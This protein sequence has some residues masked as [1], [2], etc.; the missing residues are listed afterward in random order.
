MQPAEQ[1]LPPATEPTE[2][3][4][5]PTDAPSDGLSKSALKKLQKRQAKASMKA[6]KKAAAAAEVADKAVPSAP[7]DAELVRALESQ[8]RPG[9]TPWTELPHAELRRELQA[10]G[11]AVSMKR[12]KELMPE[13]PLAAAEAP[14]GG[15]PASG[16]SHVSFPLCVSSHF[17]KSSRA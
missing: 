12:V 7:T 11:Y 17:A 2:P 4:L 16:L 8:Q 6:E 15:R 13:P 10:L 3:Q 9:G 14:P 5:P 1:Q